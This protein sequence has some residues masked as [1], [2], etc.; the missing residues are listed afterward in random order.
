MM[1]QSLHHIVGLIWICLISVGLWVIIDYENTP[2]TT[3]ATPKAWPKQTSLQA[4]PIHP[5]LLMFIHPHCPCSQASIEELARVATVTKDRL[6]IA[7]VFIQPK[8]FDKTWVETSLWHAANRI[9]GLQITI[10]LEGQEARLFGAT[11]SGQVFLYQPNGTPLFRGGLTRSR[12]HA[13]DN[14]GRSAVL[15][16]VFQKQTNTT[17]SFVFG[18][19]LF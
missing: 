15:D 16:A 14:L 3:L 1:K 19:A 5:T 4:H 8:E 2:G 10:D 12:G 13:G 7:V 6:A 18:C 11:L 9:P 17:E